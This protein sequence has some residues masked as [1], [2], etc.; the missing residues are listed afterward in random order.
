VTGPGYG[1]SP[2]HAVALRAAGI[3]VVSALLPAGCFFHLDDPVP[4]GASG[5]ASGEASGG[6]PGAGGAP[7]GGASG[8]STSGGTSAGGGSGAPAAGGA[9]SCPPGRK[10]CDTD[11]VLIDDP[12]Y[13]CSPNDNECG[14]CSQLDTA[15]TSCSSGKCVVD[16]CL[17]GFGDCD[18]L[19]RNGCEVKF[20]TSSSGS[21]PSVNAFRTSTRIKV[22]GIGDDPDWLAST[23]RR[24]RL[25]A[26]CRGCTPQFPLPKVV[27]P[28]LPRTTEDLDAWFRMAW[29]DDSLYAVFEV[30]DDELAL[31]ESQLPGSDLAKLGPSVVEDAVELLISLDRSQ[32]GFG[33]DDMQLFYG[34]DGTV[35]RPNQS[36]PAPTE[37]SLFK[38][39]TGHGCYTVEIELRFAYMAK[40][41]KYLPK[42]DQV[43]GFVAA[44]NDWDYKQADG[45]RIPE[46]QA[47][48]FSKDMPDQYWVKAESF[49]TLTLTGAL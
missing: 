39:T 44:V 1:G 49:G 27:D 19:D 48:I 9:A 23:G 33:V 34:I 32:G 6:D 11:C 41:D 5:G 8:G 20:D 17:D 14:K 40:N 42:Q 7:S 13:G 4:A 38:L 31:A 21:I 3:A 26:I 36:E 35:G 2:L 46:R 28:A 25:N 24:Q 37:P 18:G 12:A 45:G 22:D 10:H 30:R 29:D 15:K 47:H 16:G 43:I